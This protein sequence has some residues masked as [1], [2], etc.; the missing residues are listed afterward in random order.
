MSLVFCI[1]VETPR[2]TWST[3]YGLSSKDYRRADPS[4]CASFSSSRPVLSLV[5]RDDSVELS[6]CA[7]TTLSS[8][9]EAHNFENTQSQTSF[10]PKGEG[11]PT[12]TPTRW[13]FSKAKNTT[14]QRRRWLPRSLSGKHEDLHDATSVF[15]FLVTAVTRSLPNVVRLFNQ[16][17]LC[18]L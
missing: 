3:E 8:C 15:S 4:S 7:A 5:T 13:R 14:C 2:Y 12:T 16:L 6:S 9:K 10:S 18:V 17:L 1:Q 11:S